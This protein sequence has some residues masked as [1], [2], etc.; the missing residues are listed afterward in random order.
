[1][2]APPARLESGVYVAG[3]RQAPDGSAAVR[4]LERE[5]VAIA[6]IQACAT[7]N[8]Q[9]GRARFAEMPLSRKEETP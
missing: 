9:Y 7:Y 6:G 8:R 1:M 5:G 3:R 2:N 4:R